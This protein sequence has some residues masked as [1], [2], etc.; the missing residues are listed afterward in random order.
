MYSNKFNSLIL[1]LILIVVLVPTFSHNKS[2]QLKSVKS[3]NQLNQ[4][5]KFNYLDHNYFIFFHWKIH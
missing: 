3:I 5:I 1:N 4:S 2:I